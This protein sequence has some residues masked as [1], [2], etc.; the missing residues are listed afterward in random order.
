MSRVLI[1]SQ[2]K[3]SLSKAHGFGIKAHRQRRNISPFTPDIMHHHVCYWGARRGSKSRNCYSSGV[4]LTEAIESMA[5]ILNEERQRP[6][7]SYTDNWNDLKADL[8]GRP[9]INMAVLEEPRYKRLNIPT[10][11]EQK[12]RLVS[13]KPQVYSLHGSNYETLQLLFNQVH[14]EDRHEFIEKLLTFVES[15]GF[16][17]QRQGITSRNSKDMYPIF[18][19]SLNSASGTAIPNGY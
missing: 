3:P 16:C 19:W 2:Q 7:I 5:R 4:E 11:R 1:E 12:P 13:E 18:H 8:Q 9:L 10:M 6:S 14:K 17:T 15:G